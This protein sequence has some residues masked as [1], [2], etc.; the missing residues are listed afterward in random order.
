MISLPTFIQDFLEPW[1][2]FLAEDP[3]LRLLQ[4]GM[5]LVGAIVIFLVFFAT[6][7]ILLR[8]NSFIYMFICA[9]D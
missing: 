2:L 7:D 9:G 5:L 4:G 6:R 3:V 8:T 1:L